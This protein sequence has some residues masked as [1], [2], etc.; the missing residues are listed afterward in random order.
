MKMYCTSLL[1]GRLFDFLHLIVILSVFS[2]FFTLDSS[3]II[4]KCIIHFAYWCLLAFDFKSQY[5][6]IIIL[7]SN[8]LC[9]ALSISP[10]ESDCAF[11]AHRTLLSLNNMIPWRMKE[12]ANL[13][14]TY[15]RDTQKISLINF[16]HISHKDREARFVF[17][18]QILFYR[19]RTT[20]L[21]RDVADTKHK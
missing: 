17:E 9:Q 3:K 11:Y 4:Q 1:K 16:D 6:V 14:Y 2:L 7:L 13:I 8:Y 10:T 21:S 5:S 12:M 18:I 19:R 20:N 15:K